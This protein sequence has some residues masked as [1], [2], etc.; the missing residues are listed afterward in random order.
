MSYTIHIG[1]TELKAT[2]NFSGLTEMTFELTK[3]PNLLPIDFK[4]NTIF[5]LVINGVKCTPWLVG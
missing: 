3:I 5:S 4:V 1:F 2:R